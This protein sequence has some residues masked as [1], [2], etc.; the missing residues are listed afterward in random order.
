MRHA[1]HVDKFA[2]DSFL[3]D[4]VS[5]VDQ[6][7]AHCPKLPRKQ[8]NLTAFL[9]AKMFWAYGYQTSDQAAF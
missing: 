6:A 7:A 9:Y 4:G 1:P 5:G 8:L 2:K 3:C